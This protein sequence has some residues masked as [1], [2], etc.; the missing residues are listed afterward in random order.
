[1]R[2]V[3]LPSF[4]TATTTSTARSARRVEVAALRAG[5]PRQ[6]HFRARRLDDKG[7]VYIRIKAV[8]GLLNRRKLPVNVKFLLEAKKTGGEHIESTSRPGRRASRPMRGGVRHRDVRA[9]SH[10]AWLAPAWCTTSCCRGA[11]HDLH[12]GVY[13]GA[14]P[15]PMQ[16]SRMIVCALKDRDGHILIPGFYDRVVPPTQGARSLGRLP[17]T[18]RSTRKSNGRAELGG[19]PGVPCSSA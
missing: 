15:N 7:Q 8:E 9:E 1:M 19:Q 16:A 18:R 3:N 17:F 10:I 2:R 4:S 11:N 6:R 5:G 13:G 12:S 14:A